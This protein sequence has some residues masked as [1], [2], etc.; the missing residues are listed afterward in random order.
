VLPIRLVF[1]DRFDKEWIVVYGEG[2]RLSLFAVRLSVG[3][4]WREIWD[5]NIN[6]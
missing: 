6:S 3:K 1:V 5:Q 2:K 4:R